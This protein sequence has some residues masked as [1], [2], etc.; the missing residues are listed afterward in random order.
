M[1]IWAQHHLVSDWFSSAKLDLLLFKRQTVRESW[2]AKAHSSPRVSDITEGQRVT[3]HKAQSSPRWSHNESWLVC[4]LCCEARWNLLQRAGPPAW[5][6]CV[7]LK[8][9]VC[10]LGAQGGP[11]WRLQRLLLRTSWQTWARRK[12]EPSLW[13]LSSRHWMAEQKERE[14]AVKTE[15][16]DLL[17]SST[18][19]IFITACVTHLLCHLPNYL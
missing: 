7:V 14:S 19:I 4:H 6:G 8:W 17:G 13:F 1:F 18:V 2:Q 16:L 12:A 3:A 11:G 10:L 9:K 15:K 5:Q